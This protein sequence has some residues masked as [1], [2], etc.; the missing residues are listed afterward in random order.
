MKNFFAIL[1][2]SQGTPMMLGGDEVEFSKRGN[3]N[4]YCHDNELNWFNWELVEQ[5]QEHLKFFKY[6]I[7]FRKNH[8]ALQREEGFFRGIDHSQND[9]PDIGWHGVEVGQ[10]D[11]SEESH[12]IAFMIDGSMKETGAEKDDNNIYVAIN[13]FWGDLVFQLPHSGWEK[14]WHVAVN[15]AEHPGF[16]S[17]SQ[18][19]EVRN[20]R[21]LV[22]SRSLVILIDK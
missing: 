4:T 18:E 7:H 20:H 12:A 9:I 21:M 14:R 1:M 16:F 6:M 10:P 13:A 2:I 19:P 8:P 22:K 5:H 3:N 15:T 17:V 11:W